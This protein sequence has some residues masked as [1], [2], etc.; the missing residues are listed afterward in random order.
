MT[1]PD[2]QPLDAMVSH[3]Q[4]NQPTPTNWTLLDKLSSGEQLEA[5]YNQ[6]KELIA[7]CNF[8]TFKAHQSWVVQC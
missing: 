2:P 1:S 8:G 6:D 5:V 7:H 4:L 3:Q